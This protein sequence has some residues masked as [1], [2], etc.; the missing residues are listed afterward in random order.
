[1]W[2]SSAVGSRLE[3]LYH[4]S[5]ILQK[6]LGK[7]RLFCVIVESIGA[8]N[9]SACNVRKSLKRVDRYR[10]LKKG[11]LGSNRRSCNAQYSLVLPSLKNRQPSYLS[12]HLTDAHPF[13]TFLFQISPHKPN[14]TLPT[15]SFGASS[16]CRPTTFFKLLTPLR[17]VLRL[18]FA[19]GQHS[20]KTD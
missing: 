16:R 3:T 17:E 7:P 20:Q 12:R 8:L 2:P 6:S 19:K 1:M 10:P 4:C 9:P 5:S 14:T 13:A 15:V 18:A 11:L